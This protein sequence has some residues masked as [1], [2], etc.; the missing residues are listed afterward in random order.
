MRRA[1]EAFAGNARFDVRGRL[2]DGGGGVVYRAYDRELVREVAVKVMR[3]T[4]GDGMQR[5]RASFP[6]LKRLSHPNLVQLLDLVEDAGRL[7]LIMELVDGLELHDYVRHSSEPAPSGQAFHELRLRSAFLQLA[8]ALYSLHSERKVHRD[9]KPGNVRVT[10][11]GRAVLLDLDLSIDL[12]AE[13]SESGWP[14]ELRPVGTAPYMAP[15]QASSAGASFASDWYGFGVVLYE[16]LTGVLPFR[17]TDLEILL[18]KQ[19]VAPTPPEELAPNLP[20]DLAG[21]CRDLLA[22]QPSQR[23]LGVE[24]LRRLG[25]E[26][27]TVSQ[28]LSLSAIMSARTTCVGREHEIERL[29]EALERS[30]AGSYV[31]RVTGEPGVGKTALCQ[32][33]V[34]RVAHDAP[35]PLVLVGR[36]PR[37]PDRPHAALGEPVAHAVDALR[38]APRE[39]QLR[40]GQGAMR[41]LERMF[42]A[43]VAGLEE[44]RG[45]RAIPPD[46]LEQRFRA[47]DSL[48][49]MFATLAT[50]RPLLFWLDDYQ[51]ADLDT[52]RLIS[53][54][55][56]GGEPLRMLLVLSE[57]LPPGG[58]SASLPSAD[59]VIALAGL[60]RT[61]ARALAR[62]LDERRGGAR[63]APAVLYPRDT[64]PLLIQERVRYALLFDERSSEA[65]D[66][67]ALLEARVG[68]LPVEARKLL[69]IVCAAYD[70]LPQEVCERASGLSRASF[71]RQLASLRAFALVRC[72]SA[73][74][75]DFVAPSHAAVGSVLERRVPLARPQ[76]H[77]M[78]AG[79]LHV[80]EQTR[81]SARL[82]RH[83]AESGDR[84]GAAASAL[85]AAQ[86]AARALAFQRAAEL[87][88]LASTLQPAQGDD[89][90]AQL[91]GRIGDALSN[92]GASLTAA[93]MYR[94]AGQLAKGA[95]RTRPRQRAVE[96]F[97]RAGEQELGVRAV[98]ELL[99]CFDLELSRSPRAAFWGLLRKRMVV[100]LRGFGFREVSEGQVAVND[101]RAIDALWS[102]GVRLVMV[103][104]VRGADLLARGIIKAL[105]V[106]EP[107]R[108]ARALCTD[109]WIMLGYKRSH[110]THIERAVE[111]ARALIERQPSPFLDGQLKLAEGMLALARFA[112]PEAHAR[113]RA[114][115]QVMR[116]E[117][118]DVAWEIT[119]SQVYQIISLTQTGRFAEACAKYET[120]THEAR[121]RGDVWGHAQ[122]MTVGAIGVK[123]VRDL[124]NE[125]AED[126]RAGLP[127]WEQ[128]QQVQMQHVVT[129]IA[130]TYIDLYRGVTRALEQLELA[131][132]QVKRQFFLYTRYPRST[133][134]ELRGR[135]RLLVAKRRRDP[136]L[137]RAAEADARTLLAQDEGP[138]HGFGRILLAGV[139]AQRGQPER[140][141]ELLRVAVD[142]LDRRGLELWSL[143]GRYVLGR[144]LGDAD[145]RAL[146]E[147]ARGTLTARGVV[148]VGRF[149]NMM[150]PGFEEE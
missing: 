107:K 23:P 66:V 75:E 91:M 120:A 90:S 96:H 53:A 116:A 1:E 136:T 102:T 132:P 2:G 93:N 69:E 78:L 119:L 31:V 138:E 68:A 146:R 36:C 112:L 126:I 134:Y 97:L 124:P 110:L 129:L 122:L 58:L 94:Q 56:R 40:L 100:R 104:T 76:L 61:A 35:Q 142:D 30:R 74:G 29:L 17:G 63:D 34:R 48:R 79:A 18:K 64:L 11:E 144:L 6:A 5:I 111:I 84:Q 41:L 10:P 47:I 16:A 118:T 89:A 43:S 45:P 117:C 8:Q 38:D 143:S 28:R 87:L 127:R 26:E 113:F 77:G 150:L 59:E 73:L 135:A 19:E 51:W 7:L 9:V 12:D 86:D 72:F 106:G 137:L 27:E 37:H 128:L 85:A 33:L 139:C 52:Q 70:P 21:L 50:K 25:L 60:T 148:N 65:L 131:W 99:E 88:L 92:A 125:A 82:L 123:L 83:Q 81:A 4:S 105:R 149:A 101:L 140:A 32:E 55:L 109:A 133:L 57:D 114:G 54:L 14:S 3:D 67:P 108:V 103:D 95:D 147:Q 115:E 80:R 22:G 20:A 46:P 42:G 141:L 13:P 130:S 121:E 98:D 44:A 39:E 15:E 62:Q 24:V 145:G 49:V 71:S